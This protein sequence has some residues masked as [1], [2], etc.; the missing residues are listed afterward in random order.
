MCSVWRVF[1]VLV[2]KPLEDGVTSCGNG[3][4]VKSHEYR[5]NSFHRTSL[6][7]ALLIIACFTK[8]GCVANCLEQ[9]YQHHLSKNTCPLHVCVILVTPC[10][11]SDLFIVMALATVICDQWLRLTESSDDGWHFFFFSTAVIF[12]IKSSTLL[13][14]RTAIAHLTDYSIV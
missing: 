2:G 3:S 8:W 9:V 4:L 14:R 11:S 6:C 10:K 1:Q 12:L 5:R 13:L 7:P